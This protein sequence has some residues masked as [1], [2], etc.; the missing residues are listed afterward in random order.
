MAKLLSIKR[1]E[2]LLAKLHAEIA[3]R[4]Q[5]E[6]EVGA[7]YDAQTAM[8]EQEFAEERE[9][10]TQEYEQQREGLQK[11]YDA[12]TQAAHDQFEADSRSTQAEYDRVV[13]TIEKQYESD[14]AAAHENY[15]ESHWLIESCFDDAADDG[16]QHQYEIQKFQAVKTKEHFLADWEALEEDVEKITE[17]MRRR[18]QWRDFETPPSGDAP[19]D[20]AEAQERFDD[21]VESARQAIRRLRAQKLPRLFIGWFP[22]LLFLVLVGGMGVSAAFFVDPAWLRMPVSTTT[23]EWY[24]ICGGAAVI[25]TLLIGGVLFGIARRRSGRVFEQLQAQLVQAKSAV[26]FWQ[27]AAKRELNRMK[28][29]S[30]EWGKAV[31]GRREHGRK[32]ADLAF[33][34][35]LSQYAEAKQA[36]LKEAHTRFPELLREISERHKQQIEEAEKTYPRRIAQREQQFQADCQELDSRKSARLTNHETGFG[37]DWSQLATRWKSAVHETLE[38]AGAMNDLSQEAFGEW[39]KMAEAWHG[40]KTF[41]PAIRIGELDVDLARVENGLP[42][43]SR[44]VPERTRFA[45]PAVLGFPENASLLLKANGL[46]R[47]VA[48]QTLQTAMLRFLTTI[49]PGRIRFTILDPVGLGENFSAFMHLADYDELMI[50]NRIWTENSHIE[51]RLA[52]LTEHMEGIFQTYLRNEFKTIQEYNA[53]AGEVAEPYHVLVVA[54]FPMNFTEAAARRLVSI[55]TSGPKCGI[56]TLMS[57]DT[58]QP[59]PHRFELADIEQ[60]A[61]TLTWQNDRFVW[62]RE[63]FRS[64]PLTLDPPPESD[65]FVSIVRNVGIESKDAR[66]VEVPFEL[67]APPNGR[68][69]TSSSRTGLDV[70]LGRAGATKLQHMRLG[71]GTSQHVL[72]A[73]KTGSGKSTFL[74]ALIT[75]LALH[76]SSDEIEFY[77]IDFKKGVEFKTYA[78]YG[79]PHA[80]VIAIESDREFGL[81]VLQRLDGV[82]K[83]RGD[84]FRHHGVQDLPSYREA[85]PDSHMPRLLLVIDEFHEFFVEDDKI[86]QTAALLLDRLVRQGRAFGIHVLLGSQTLGGAYSLARST[87]G[88]VAVR[89]ALQCSETD[90]HLILSEENAAARLLTRPGE[91]IYNDANG[92][93]EGNHPFQI[94][95]LGEERREI[96][97]EEMRELARSRDIVVP[98]PI[99]FEGNIPADPAA[100][101]DLSQLLQFP[102]WEAPPLEPTIWLGDPVEIKGPTSVR[103]RRQSGSNMVI[104]GQDDVAAFGI[105][106]SAMVSLAGQAKPVDSEDDEGLAQYYVFDGGSSVTEETD[107]WQHLADAL[108]HS[109]QVVPPRRASAAIA[110]IAEELTRRSEQ[111]DDDSPPLCLFIFNLG[112]FRDLRKDDDDFGLGGFGKDKPASAAEQFSKV[113]RDGPPLGIHMILWSDSYNNANRWMSTQTL[114]ELEVR[115]AFQMSA[116]DSSHL[117]DSTAA[118]RLGTNRA[119]LCLMEQGSTE[120]FRP[121]GAPSQEWLDRVTGLLRDGKAEDTAEDTAQETVDGAREYWDSIDTWKVS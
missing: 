121:Y 41:P 112:R 86:G 3:V 87:L 56:Y 4:A 51:Q 6:G 15:D 35:Q 102:L 89:V 49:P 81:S 25:V 71:H 108:P 91:A 75:N 45:I 62:E 34:Q 30:S 42:P 76:Y 10:L 40:P 50:S 53:H 66:R 95:W 55:A 82:L 106:A 14:V 13:A 77:L 115:V 7:N 96:Y 57:V 22:F 85:Q 37:R 54:N 24:A 116:T 1:Q 44:L 33:Q 27:A 65:E 60:C 38:T 8:L 47:Q 39:K 111:P 109:V 43:D 20:Q 120:K 73:G 32:K 69:W 52:D 17:L 105:M 11:E 84:L 114:R 117:L 119:L 9:R 63:S 110:Q 31:R 80:R 61:T 58:N 103:L 83:E 93:I 21:S 104:V 64:L 99:I 29:E 72:V 48:V 113:L 118:G 46:G 23:E 90:A 88:Q 101:P 12:V 36:A 26:R 92:L 16:P 70:P 74:H 18:R 68:L 28:K 94:A 107:A 59:M 19:A 97:L 78:A 100:N 98:P 67:I 79:L 2:Q 5:T